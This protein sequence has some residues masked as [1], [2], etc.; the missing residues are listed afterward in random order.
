LPAGRYVCIEVSDD[1]CGMT[2]ETLA[3][4]FDPFFST[5]FT[6][7]GL[8]LSAVLGIVRGHRGAI[9]VISEVGVGTR[10]SVFLP[11][12]TPPAVSPRAPRQRRRAGFRGSGAVLV[13]DDEE[14]VRGLARSMLREMGFQVLV[15]SDGVEAMQV[16]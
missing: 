15:A 16:L 1:G 7:R 11:A 14:A 12:S 5:K 2:P 8:G 10:F 9:K 13:V 4:I 6:G 3:K